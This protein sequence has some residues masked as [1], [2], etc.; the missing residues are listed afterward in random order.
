VYTSPFPEWYHRV[1]LPNRVKVP[2]EFTKFSGQD[3]TSTVEHIARYLMQLRE[4]STNEAFRIRYFP[5]SLT[6]PA[7]TWFTSLPAHSICSWKDLEQKFHSHYYTG[8]NEKKL[9]DLA[10]LRQRNI[11]T[12]MEFLRRFRETKSMCFSLSIPDDQLVGMAVA[13]MLPA[14]QEKLFGMEF[15]DLGQLSHR[16]SLMSNQACGFKKDSRFIKHNDIAEIYNQFLERADQG[17][18]YDDEEE[19]AAAEIVWGKE[20]VT[21]NQ[22]WI[23]QA[24]G[25]YDFNV[26]KADKLFESLVKEGRIKLPEGHSMLRPDGVKDKKYC[27]F[28]DRN[29]HSIN[30]CRVFRARIQ[31]AIQE[32]HLKFDNKMKLD[33]NPFPQNM[34]GF[35]VNMVSA[36]EEKGKVKVLT[37]AKAKQDGSVDPARQVTVEQIHKGEPRFLKSQIEVG[38]S[39]KP[40][41]TSRILLNK[42]QCQQEKE[43]Y[44][45]HKYE[46]EKR[47]Y[48]E[49]MHRK[50]QEKYARE[51]ERAHWGCA[52]FKHYWN[53]GLKLPTLNNC[54]ECSDRYTEYRQDTAN[55]RSVHERIG[56]INPSDGQRLKI[57]ELDDQLGK[58]YADHRWVDHE[59]EEDREYVLQKG[60][61]CPPGLRKSQKRRVQRL[62]NQELRQAGIKRRQ[63]WRPKDKPDES[64]RSANTCMV[65]FLPNQFMALANQIVQEEV[66]PDID[67]AEQAGLMAQLVLTK[68]A[69]FDKPVKNQH[70]RLLYL[71]GYVNGKPLTKMFVDGGAA[72]NVM[73]YTTFRNLGMGPRDLMPTSIV[74]NDFAG[75]P[76]DT[77]GCVHVDLM[78]RSK[79]LLTTFFVI[80]GKGAYSLLLGR[81]WIH[82]N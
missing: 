13:G 55:R 28:H 33:G 81:D 72:I 41:V 50:E 30:E 19:I 20:P 43:R 69:T 47:R 57:N 53:E 48:E 51:Q 14:V 68:Q 77:K 4:A 79:T 71:R 1:A 10:T 2:A 40:R 59:E 8:S 60:Q 75:N 27:G 62:R 31:K 46:E 9:I 11:E 39:S 7:F 67:E 73:P 15:E 23:K 17:E 66:L 34:V 58:R 6:G 29:S 38:E 37:S 5:L 76:S 12:P 16:F 25:T 49:E 42:W 21:V 54:P 44:Q 56:R 24:K 18:E 65:C 45:K 74:L 82:A 61:W 3:D 78:I 32:G 63:V 70:M 36:V 80:E 26:T 22:R 64:G 52:F 35:S